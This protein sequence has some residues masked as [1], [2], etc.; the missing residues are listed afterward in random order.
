MIRRLQ[1]V[2]QMVQ[3]LAPG[4]TV[5]NVAHSPSS[6]H[7]HVS[8]LAHLGFENLCEESYVTN[9]DV[10]YRLIR[11]DALPMARI[12]APDQ[13]VV[14]FRYQNYMIGNQTF[15]K[16]CSRALHP[17]FPILNLSGGA[18]HP[19]PMLDTALQCLR[20]F[21]ESV[22]TDFQFFRNE[23]IDSLFQNYVQGQSCPSQGAYAAISMV[24]A[25]ASW[26][27]HGAQNAI[28]ERL[29]ETAM[30]VLP[31]IMMEAPDTLAVGAMLLMTTYLE[32]TSRSSAAATLLGSVTQMMLL[33]G[34]HVATSS[35][36]L[37][38]D[39]LHD[40]RL[41][42]R[43]YVMDQRLSLRL[44][45]SPLL[46]ARLVV[47]L[48][49]ENPVD[50]HGV[51]NLPEGRSV[52]YLRQQVLLAKI[53]ARV[54]NDLRSPLP[55]AKGSQNH[56]KATSKLLSE[57]QQWANDLP[58][59]CRPPNV[60]EDLPI[61]HSL[62]ITSLHRSYFQTIIAI[63]SSIFCHVPYF[64][65]PAIR[66]ITMKVVDECASAA[67]NILCLS[68]HTEKGHQFM[69]DVCHDLGWSI[70]GLLLS[71]VLNRQTPGA[72]QDMEL[73]KKFVASFEAN[74]PQHDGKVVYEALTIIYKSALE[75][76]SHTNQDQDQP[77]PAWSRL[78]VPASDL[79]LNPPSFD[80]HSD[81]TCIY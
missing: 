13:P 23:E 42:S 74:K 18:M 22:N 75:A 62:Q 68:M 73:L 37:S 36:A 46:T 25:C 59:S 79:Q 3:N 5:E 6:R 30:R 17:N 34:Y 16:L 53:Q 77:D 33:A 29:V 41:L 50:H 66:G 69:L 65:D 52:N 61:S 26:T 78:P 10:L 70:D 55:C 47:G 60:A 76:L 9:P 57:L 31:G 8:P 38:T 81:N 14:K 72:H 54:Y 64:S 58:A 40:S 2:E 56:L 67:R 1:Q 51:I 7:L 24:C 15:S 44:F 48:P 49:D 12:G 63:H 45:K 11:R 20:I 71:I 28:T 43:A 80:D 4:H 32:S 35:G 27:L 39:Q 21:L 19:I